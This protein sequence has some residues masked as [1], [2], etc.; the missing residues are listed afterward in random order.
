[1]DGWADGPASAGNA[2][3]LAK[4]P[5]FDAF[6]NAY[7]HTELG[8]SGLDVGLPAGQMGNSEVGH[9]NI[10]AGR[11]IYQDL[12]RVSQ[13]IK[14][15][16]FFRN[17]VI[18]DAMRTA[19]GNGRRLHLMGLLSDGGVHSHATHLYALVE[20]AKQNGVKDVYI[21]A[22]LD[23]RDVPPDSGL[24]SVEKL[25]DRLKEIGLGRIATVSGRYYA[26]D[27]DQRWERTKL[28]WDAIVEGHG[29]T[30]ASGAEAVQDS[31]DA[32]IFDEFVKPAVVVDDL[33]DEG[34]PLV[35]DS[36]AVVFFNFRPDRAR[37]LT[38]AFIVPDFKGFDRGPKSPAVYFA[39]MTE[40]DKKFP[41]PIAFPQ[42][43]I[44]NTL[45]EVL[46][47]NGLKQLHT[48]ETEKYAHVTFF[49][50][51]GLEA[52]VPGEDRVLIPSPKV[53]TYDLKPEMSAREVT[54][55]V[56]AEIATDKYDV[57]IMNYANADMVGHTAIKTAVVKAVETVDECLGKVVEA[58]LAKGGAVLITADHGNA[59]KIAEPGTDLP[60]TAHTTNPVPFI[61]V[62]EK[63]KKLRGGGI[64]AD[65][66][67]T[68]LDLLGL[69]KPPEMTGKSLIC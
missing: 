35:R 26:M 9:L 15:G 63:N 21:H 56:V 6:L 25:D 64:L 17:P 60:F 23:G 13:A 43:E 42:E 66:A 53:A 3:S 47:A 31:Y 59:D 44:K 37:Q 52:A 62:S 12:T 10:G 45:A 40:Y 8:A 14:D 27:R 18:L 33:F 22:F 38:R 51:G 46:S 50:N 57:V 39:T 7:P 41:S 11:I 24:K 19:A 67:P 69:P 61:L 54:D 32:E 16:S 30:A 58:V 48:A 28:A 4:T 55:S 29:E 20:M 1:M 36:D 65:I 2:I 49:F 34:K 68:M 5:N